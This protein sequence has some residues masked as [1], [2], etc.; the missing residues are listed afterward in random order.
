MELKV[1]LTLSK[2]TPGTHVYSTSDAQA[3]VKSVYIAKSAITGEPPKEV[4]L[5]I[6][7]E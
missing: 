1:K 4:T 6:T 7:T 2:S 5:T 3:P